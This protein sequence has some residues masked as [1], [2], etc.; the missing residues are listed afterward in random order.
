MLTI[1]YITTDKTSIYRPAVQR[2]PLIFVRKTKP[3][4][5]FRETV[6]F[7]FKNRIKDKRH[8]LGE[9]EKFLTLQ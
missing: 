8:S 2:T 4:M 5:L 1:M 3:S 7:Y 9:I 6:V